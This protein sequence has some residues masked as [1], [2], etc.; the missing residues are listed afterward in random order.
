MS[1]VMAIVSERTDEILIGRKVAFNFTQLIKDV[2]RGVLI[3]LRN[4][5]LEIGIIII[6]ALVNLL[7]GLIFAPF[8]VI[9][10]PL[11]AIITFLV[12]AYFYGF[13]TMDY[14]SERN[15]LNVRQSIRFIR[16]YKGIALANGTIFTMWLIVPVLGTYIGT[17]F[18]PITCTVGATLAIHERT[19][20]NLLEG[21]E[22][23]N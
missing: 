10:T 22:K 9:T 16:K 5:F 19:N 17:I 3:A 12:G 20:G 11:F 4:M 14:S 13:S 21:L 6:L 7:V 2:W 15:K 1:P 18:A 8:A 23:R